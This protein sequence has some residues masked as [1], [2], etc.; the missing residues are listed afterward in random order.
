M[1]FSIHVGPID[2]IEHNR[3][4]DEAHT[5]PLKSTDHLAM[6]ESG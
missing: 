2:D 5:I 3:R 1:W 6:R 4:H